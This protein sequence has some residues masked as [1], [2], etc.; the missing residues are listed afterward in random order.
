MIGNVT[1]ELVIAGIVRFVLPMPVG[2]RS[3]IRIILKV[4]NTRRITPISVGRENRRQEATP[5]RT[6]CRCASS[7]NV[8]AAYHIKRERALHLAFDSRVY[9]CS[10]VSTV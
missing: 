5:G 8:G 10:V 1:L 7:W 9:D 3:I 4:P 6:V 2:Q